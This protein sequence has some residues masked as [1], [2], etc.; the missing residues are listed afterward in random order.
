MQTQNLSSIEKRRFNSLTD[1]IRTVE[2]RAAKLRTALAKAEGELKGTVINVYEI[3]Q[4]DDF[5]KAYRNEFLHANERRLIL[6]GFIQEMTPMVT[7]ILKETKPLK[8]EIEDIVRAADDRAK[9]IQMLDEQLKIDGDLPADQRR[10]L[11]E[12]RTKAA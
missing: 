7:E 6:E 9:T 4:S 5:F 3:S 8:E 2:A 1:H 12:L 10:L 11:L